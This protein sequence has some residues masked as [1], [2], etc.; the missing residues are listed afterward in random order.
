MRLD[1]NHRYLQATAA[2]KTGLNYL[3]CIYSMKLVSLKQP[4]TKG[5]SMSEAL[6]KSRIDAIRRKD[7]FIEF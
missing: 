2:S 4:V 7:F 5:L 3:G 6:E 1:E